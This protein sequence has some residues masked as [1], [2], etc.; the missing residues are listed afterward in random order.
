MVISFFLF[1]STGFRAECAVLKWRFEEEVQV[2]SAIVQQV[3]QLANSR[4]TVDVFAFRFFFQSIPS[5]TY[6]PFIMKRNRKRVGIFNEEGKKLYFRSNTSVS[7][8]RSR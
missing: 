3:Q 1:Q 6:S 8:S 7:G 4:T 5:G 2:C